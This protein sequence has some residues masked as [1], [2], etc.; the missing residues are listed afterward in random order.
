MAPTPWRETDKYK[1][2][3]KTASKEDWAV[4]MQRR[5]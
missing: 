5:G 2:S 1:G 4:G 3:W